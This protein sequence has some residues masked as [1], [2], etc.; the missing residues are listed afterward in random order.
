MCFGIKYWLKS[1]KKKEKASSDFYRQWEKDHTEQ[2]IEISKLRKKCEKV[3]E[4]LYKEQREKW[5]LERKN[6]KLQAYLKTLKK[7]RT[8]R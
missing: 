3:E 2:R 6:K 4:L 8:K 7:E 1:P 5:H